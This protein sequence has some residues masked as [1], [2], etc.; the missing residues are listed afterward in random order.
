LGGFLKRK[1]KEQKGAKIAKRRL[2]YPEVLFA[3]F[4]TFCP[5]CFLLPDSEGDLK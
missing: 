5:F 3:P 1:Q 4:V 2:I